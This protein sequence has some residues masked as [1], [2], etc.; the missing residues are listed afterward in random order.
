MVQGLSERADKVRNRQVQPNVDNML[1]ITNDG[2]M[3]AL[4]QRLMTSL[5]PDDSNSKVN[6]CVSNIY[7]IWQEGMDKKLTQL[8]FCDLSTP[9]EEGSFNVYD[10]VKKKLMAQGVPDKE[11]A[12]IHDAKTEQ[13][14]DDLFSKVRRG[15]VRVLIGSTFKMGS[16]TNVQDKLVALHHLDVPWRPSD[17]EQRQGRIL[18]QGNKN[19]EV[20]VF[21]YVTESTFDAYSWQLIE[22]KQKFISQIITSKSPVRGAEDI[23]E[24]AL[25]YAEVKALAAGS[26]LIKEKMDLD[27]EVARLKLLK[28]AYN[29]QRY[30]LEDS[31]NRSLPAQIKAEAERIA[32]YASD[33]SHRNALTPDDNEKFRMTV[34][35]II[36]NEKG[37][38]GKALLTALEQ[39]NPRESTNIGQYRGFE[40]WQSFD[41]FNHQ[42]KMELRHALNHS[43]YLGV[44]P[45]GNIQRMDNLL[46]AIEEHMIICEE[47]CNT[48]KEQLGNAKAELEKPF[49]FDESL[50]EKSVRLAEL[51]SLLSM[52]QKMNPELVED[53]QGEESVIREQSDEPER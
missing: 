47:K 46:E 42:F 29:S 18:R 17:V 20:E 39:V 26:P 49:L 4:D 53:C 10:D 2:R 25:S 34:S 19:E 11:I 50:K 28:S 40:M 52:D 48:L 7:R 16:G 6:T 9:K 38:A 37:E 22:Q 44:D 43:M 5:L 31:I 1:R 30:R 45:H 36:Y 33:I 41:S 21:R 12:F 14:K 32:G 27:V 13:Q 8:V 24:V 15:D 51:D 35:E 3:L 23:D